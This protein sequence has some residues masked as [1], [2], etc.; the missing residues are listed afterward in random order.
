ML[1]KFGKFWKTISLL[2][3]TWIFYGVFGFEFAVVTA[4]SL[5]LAT[6]L[7]DTSKFI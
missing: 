1:F 3:G 7:K 5:I 6:N 4:L 2:M